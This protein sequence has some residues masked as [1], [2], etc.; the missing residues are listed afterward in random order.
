M[1]LMARDARVL[2]SLPG[3]AEGDPISVQRP[4]AGPAANGPATRLRSRLRSW[5]LNARRRAFPF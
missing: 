3:T 1:L 4:R 2:A 5:E